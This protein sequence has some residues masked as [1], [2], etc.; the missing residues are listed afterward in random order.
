MDADDAAAL[1]VE[2]ADFE[3]D[4]DDLC[5][6]VEELLLTSAAAEDSEAEEV[7]MPLLALEAELVLTQLDDD[8]A[9]TVSSSV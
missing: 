5:E 4:V 9:C 2:D 8:P 1:L 6:V 7:L 3:E